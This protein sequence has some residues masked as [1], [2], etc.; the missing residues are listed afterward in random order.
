MRR[1]VIVGGGFGGLITAKK[2]R[3]APVDIT[4][5][6]RA[7]YH[8][9]QPLLYQVAM[10]GLSPADIAVPIRSA[11]HKNKNTHVLL[12]HVVSVDLAARKV[13]LLS[14]QALDY[15]NLVLAAGAGT[16]YFGHPEWS[17][18]APGL[19][20]LDEAVEI[21]RRVLLAFEA[22]EREP[23]PEKR[24]A[25]L[26]FVVIG[27]GP[28]G[29]ELAGAL[30]ELARF[31]LARDFRTICPADAEVTLL[32]AAPR[33]LLPFDERLSEKAVKQ[34]NELGVTVRTNTMVTKI[35]E[36]GVHV[37]LP[38]GSAELIPASTELWGAGVQGRPLAKT[39]GV[40]LDRG[41]RVIV[42]DDNSIP[43][44][45]EVFVLGDM[46]HQKGADGKPLP[47]L[48]PVAMQ[49]AR[50]TAANLLRDIEGKPRKPFRYRDKGSMATIGR[51]R[52][53]AQTKRLKFSG[54]PAW[55]AWIFVHL[56]FLVGFRNRFLVFYNWIYGYLTYR[57]GARLI[58]GRRLRAGVPQQVVEPSEVERAAARING[59]GKGDRP[60]Q[61]GEVPTATH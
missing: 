5:V 46:A 12:D 37:K 32:E 34:L 11:L 58:T 47:G 23:D 6:D 8:L 48:A 51:S 41:G 38:D 28:T 20:D 57:R 36:A 15:D 16:N 52:A 30:A 44:H 18:F 31:V 26:R 9:F 21:R 14:G 45:P 59:G 54:F 24:K 13:H 10:A 1:V 56:W 55:L 60:H 17:T 4:L 19:K 22:A 3:K 33:I 35:D 7:N 42:G 53:V 49:Q 61:I 2:L 43:G 39:L 29:V 25:L 40:E 50:N 27:G